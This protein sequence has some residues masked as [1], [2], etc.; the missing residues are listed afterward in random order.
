M[1]ALAIGWISLMRVTSSKVGVHVGPLLTVHLKVTLV[2][3]VTPVMVVFLLA[4]LVMVAV[5]LVILHN[6]VPTVGATAFIAKIVLLHW[7]WSKPALAIE[8][9]S[10][11]FTVT[12]S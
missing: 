7:L 6:P 11:K 3:A 2:P 1:P 4:V 9:V 8:G 10:Q 12:S 5:P